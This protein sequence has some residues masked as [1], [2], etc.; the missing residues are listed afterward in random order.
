MTT[1]W[2]YHPISQLRQRRR[3]GHIT[4]YLNYANDDVL[5]ISPNISTTPTTTCWSYH[6]ISQLRQRRRPQQRQRRQAC[7]N[8]TI[9]HLRQR[10]RAN[11]ITPNTS[12]KFDDAYAADDELFITWS[13]P[14]LRFRRAKKRQ[15]ICKHFHSFLK[16]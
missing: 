5:V 15:M 13:I 12:S 8:T 1:S 3:A 14:H 7:H 6:P 4:Q 2:S 10:R 16:I 11:H 9:P